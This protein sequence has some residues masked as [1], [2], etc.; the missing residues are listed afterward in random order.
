MFHLASELIN[1]HQAGRID[2][3]RARMG[4]LKD[5]YKRVHSLLKSYNQDSIAKTSFANLSK[6]RV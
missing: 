4:E 1:Q 5:S 2:E 3:A 6:P